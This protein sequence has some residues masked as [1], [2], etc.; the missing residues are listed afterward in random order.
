MPWSGVPPKPANCRCHHTAARHCPQLLSVAIVS[1]QKNN[2]RIVIQTVSPA[3]CGQPNTPAR[4]HIRTPARKNKGMASWLALHRQTLELPSQLLPPH[5]LAPHLSLPF[6]LGTWIS[7][8]SL[9]ASLPDGLQTTLV[10]GL[11]LQSH[12]S[13]S[14]RPGHISKIMGCSPWKDK[15]QPEIH[16]KMAWKLPHT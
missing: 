15:L 1:H 13:E 7:P 4:C 16:M 12:V 10:S 2:G 14:Y 8:A 9:P 11:A 3:D 6:G 5:T